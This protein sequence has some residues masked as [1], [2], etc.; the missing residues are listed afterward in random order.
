MIPNFGHW[1]VGCR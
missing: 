1:T